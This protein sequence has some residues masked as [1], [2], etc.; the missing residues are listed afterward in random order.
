MRGIIIVLSALAVAGCSS[1]EERVCHK[2]LSDQLLNPETLEIAEFNHLSYERFK[3]R[4]VQIVYRQLGSPNGV[5]GLAERNVDT[6]LQ[7]MGASDNK[8]Y[9][10]RY[11][12]EARAGAKI[13][14]INLC[15]VTT[16][17]CD[18]IDAEAPFANNR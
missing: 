13:T 6:T 18:C 8:F 12:A 17:E 7:R 15:R 11:K 5:R 2:A 14:S 1:A 16:D 10:V 9:E 3:Q 4:L